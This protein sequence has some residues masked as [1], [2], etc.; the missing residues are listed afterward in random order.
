MRSLSAADNGMYGAQQVKHEA[1]DL[2][3]W[4]LDQALIWISSRD[5]AWVVGRKSWVDYRLA[6]LPTPDGRYP[7]NDFVVIPKE[8]ERQLLLFLCK[9][10]IDASHGTEKLSPLWFDHAEYLQSMDETLLVNHVERINS[11]ENTLSIRVASV[12]MLAQFPP[13]GHRSAAGRKPGYDWDRIREFVFE[14][15]E[16]NGLPDPDD[17]EFSSQEAVV[18]RVL[19]YCQ[20]ELNR[21]P[22]VSTVRERV[23]GWIAAYRSR[24]SR[25]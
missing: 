10:Q 4:T 17:P 9:G 24:L 23:K 21:E 22:G 25:N 16:E 6:H 8:A 11:D 1:F 14:L 2:P 20:R 15:F 12:Q 3:R 5:P 19:E 18:N 7:G 13:I